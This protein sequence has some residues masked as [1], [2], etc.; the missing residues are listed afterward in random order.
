MFDVVFPN[1]F[2]LLWLDELL[3]KLGYCEVET[4]KMYSFSTDENNLTLIEGE[5]DLWGEVHKAMICGDLEIWVE[6]CE[7]R[8]SDDLVDVPVEEEEDDSE[9]DWEKECYNKANVESDNEIMDDLE[10]VEHVDPNAE[11]GG[12]KIQAQPGENNEQLGLSI[13]GG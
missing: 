9:S 8:A 6:G 2:G 13:V 5:L 12:M 3:M 11:F 7:L 4:S 10:F 1:D